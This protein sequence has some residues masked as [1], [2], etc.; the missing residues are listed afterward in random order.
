M[1]AVNLVSPRQHPGFLAV[2]CRGCMAAGGLHSAAAI[3]RRV[4]RRSALGAVHVL[5]Q[6]TQLTQSCA[7]VPTMRRHS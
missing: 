3:E 6:R 5:G 7:Y 2:K 4:D 1:A